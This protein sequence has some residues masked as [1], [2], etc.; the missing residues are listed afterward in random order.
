MS[1]LTFRPAKPVLGFLHRQ[2]TMARPGWF[3]TPSCASSTAKTRRRKLRLREPP[4]ADPPAYLH[5]VDGKNA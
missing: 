2:R 1:T 4:P 5:I 3:A